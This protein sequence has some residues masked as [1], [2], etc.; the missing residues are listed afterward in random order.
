MKQLRILEY[1]TSIAAAWCGQQFAQWGSDVILL[2]DTTGSP[3]R[4]AAPSVKKDGGT[5][6]LLWENLHRRKRLQS[7]E[8]L[9]K[10]LWETSDVI[11]TDQ[12][13]SRLGM[14]KPPGVI[15]IS[16]TPFGTT[17]PFSTRQA[18]ELTIEASAGYLSLNGKMGHAPLRA[19]G[20][21]IGYYCG[22]TAFVG[23]LAA[24]HKRQV[25]GTGETVDVSCFDSVVTMVPFVRAQYSGSPEE[26]EGGPGSGVRLFP[27]GDGYLSLNLRSQRAFDRLLE[28]LD[29]DP[30]SIPESVSTP[31][32]RMNDAAVAEFLKSNSKGTS[33]RAIFR[34][35][36]ETSSQPVGLLNTPGEA[37]TNDH[38]VETG[39]FRSHHHQL[40]DLKVNG[41]PGRISGLEDTASTPAPVKMEPNL[42]WRQRISFPIEA[43]PN[44]NSSNRPLENI[45]IIDLTQ[46]WIGPFATQLLADLGADVIKIE[47][48][49]R[50]DVWRGARSP[51]EVAAVTNANAHPLNACGRF[52][53]A[54]RNKRGLCLD[55]TTEKGRSLILELI[56]DADIIIENFTPRVMDK[57]GLQY[58]VLQAVNPEI[59]SVCCSGYGKEGPYA[60]YKANGTTI[61]ALA[62]WDAL[63]SNPQ[64]E[65]MVMGFYQADAIT[66]MHLAAMTLAAL[67]QR[68]ITGEGQSVS[69]SMIEA[70]L[71]YIG[72]DILAASYGTDSISHGNNHPDMALQGIYPCK[73]LDKWIAIS[74]RNEVEWNDFESIVGLSGYDTESA[75]EE[76]ANQLYSVISD[77]TRS[78]QPEQVS[79][80]LQATGIPAEEV[81]DI[82]RILD[83]PHLAAKQWFIP[84]S[85]PDLQ[86]CL[87]G[88]FPWQFS[89]SELVV[90]RPAPRIGEHSIEILSEDLGL[91]AGEIQELI[92]A[93]ITGQLL[94]K[95]Q[96]DPG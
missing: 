83:H 75:R 52:N 81:L 48:L 94:E 66:G 49:R 78:R 79:E 5:Y 84:V 39:Y 65:P 7:L 68:D 19:P 18:T 14:E 64:E 15:V 54:N 90:S 32:K 80:Q 73:G 55:L 51:D 63:F 69:A 91:S 67:N 62:G 86:T 85:H 24:L 27:I 25:T 33:A 45:R 4:D 59:I 10:D 46:A 37:L 88:G 76:N 43:E 23:A 20:H 70:A 95:V 8:S 41:P 82:L 6:S 35:F 3:L 2:E 17:G 29:I 60:N 31:E 28:L 38:L 34:A 21:L 61:E 58:E 44:E 87:H 36:N 42:K 53:G 96:S 30:Y 71:T 93:N 26:R 11:I 47:S 1:S 40:G 50:P 77:W 13:F 89:S 9:T 57:F 56:K 92:N 74:V 22:V 72:E 12:P 16:I